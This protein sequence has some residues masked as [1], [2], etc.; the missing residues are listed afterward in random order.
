MNVVGYKLQLLPVVNIQQVDVLL[1]A[2]FLLS[3][4][5]TGHCEYCCSQAMQL[6]SGCNSRPR[7]SNSYGP[8]V[9]ITQFAITNW[10][11]NPRYCRSILGTWAFS[12]TA[13][14]VWNSLP[15]C[16]IGLLSLNVL[17]GNWK[18]FL[19]P[20]MNSIVVPVSQIRAS[21][22]THYTVTFTFLLADFISEV[23]FVQVLHMSSLHLYLCC[24]EIPDY[25]LFM[26]GK[27]WMPVVPCGLWSCR[28]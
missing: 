21:Y 14:T 6:A 26:K 3:T 16:M 25:S 5:N 19:L 7:I 24:A 27:V 11:S 18:G 15:N 1:I 9:E 23:S 17:G 2:R 10:Y 12:V 28:K 13:L 8:F 22:I 4:C 20:D